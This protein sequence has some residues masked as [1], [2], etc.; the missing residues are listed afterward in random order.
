[1]FGRSRTVSF[2]AVVKLVSRM[3]P[4]WA[5]GRGDLAM[6]DNGTGGMDNNF[7]LGSISQV[8]RDD[9]AKAFSVPGFSASGLLVTGQPRHCACLASS[10]TRGRTTSSAWIA[11]T[12]DLLC[13]RMY[14]AVALCESWL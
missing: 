3:R 2:C 12:I 11:E 1:M 4:R 7:N 6:P 10:C 9:L 13:N 5:N 14:A 8:H